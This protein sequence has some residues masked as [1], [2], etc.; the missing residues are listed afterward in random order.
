[1]SAEA[2]GDDAKARNFYAA[3]LKSTDNGSRSSR[4]EF[5][6]MKA[7]LSSTALAVE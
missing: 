7:F 5:D 1:L 2:V 6:H 4:P 3:L